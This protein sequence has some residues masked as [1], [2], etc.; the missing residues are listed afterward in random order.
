MPLS[1]PTPVADSRDRPPIWLFGLLFGVLVALGLVEEGLRNV[2][3]YERHGVFAGE[4]WRLLTGH[5]VHG[6]TQHLLL[7]LAG[8]L[9]IAALFPR[10][11]SSVEWLFVGLSSVVVMD[12]AFVFYEP[13]LQWYVGFSGVLHGALAAGAV[14]WWRSEPKPV[15]L[16]LTVV[17]IGKLLWEQWR[18]ALPLSGDLPVVVD[19]HLY[20]AIGGA[21]AASILW[22]FR[23]LW[24]F[25]HRSL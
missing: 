8:L 4:Y 9:L 17:L 10:D 2:L 12:V 18:G 16:V 22:A 20:G 7:N 3:L 19:A 23:Q 11:Y 21:A 6:S 13:Q 24:P 1:D 5:L 25:G 14:A 15:A